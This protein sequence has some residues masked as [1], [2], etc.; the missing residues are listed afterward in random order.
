[1]RKAQIYLTAA[2]LAFL[3][4]TSLSALAFAPDGSSYEGMDNDL[5][6]PDMWEGRSFSY[7]RDADGAYLS[8]MMTEENVTDS[9]YISV[10]TYDGLQIYYSA[11]SGDWEEGITMDIGLDVLGIL[12]FKDL[13]DDGEYDPLVDELISTLPLSSS[14]LHLDFIPGDDPVEPPE[15]P[16][17]S[18]DE[19][20]KGYEE[21]YDEGY[22]VGYQVGKEH[23]ETGMEYFPDPW[24]YFPELEDLFGDWD[25]DWYDDDWDEDWDNWYDD[26]WDDEWDLP[27]F[28]IIENDDGSITV[29]IIDPDGTE[30]SYTFDSYDELEDWLMSQ[31]PD[32]WDD[33]WDDWEDDWDLP[34]FEVIEN[35]DGTI[36][37]VIIHEDGTEEKLL[38]QDYIE[39]EEWFMKEIPEIPGELPE[40]PEYPPEMPELDPYYE[41]YLFGLMDGFFLGYMEGYGIDDDAFLPCCE[42]EIIWDENDHDEWGW[43][44]DHWY[45]EPWPMPVD[46]FL[47]IQ[48]EKEIYGT[49]GYDLSY[50]VSDL[51]GYVNFN[52]Y[53]SGPLAGEMAFKPVLGLEIHVD[54]PYTR[55]DTQT[56]VIMDTSFSSLSYTG[57]VFYILEDG[58]VFEGSE[59]SIDT[60]VETPE[61]PW[62][63]F[64]KDGNELSVGISSYY[65]DYRE[66]EDLYSQGIYSFEGLIITL[67]SS[68]NDHVP[69]EDET[70]DPEDNPQRPGDDNLEAGD[71]QEEDD[72][73]SFK[74]SDD[75]ESSEKGAASDDASIDGYTVIGILMIAVIIGL[76]IT[77]GYLAY[78]KYR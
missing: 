62:T 77:A 46:H 10:S 40:D 78:R 53:A 15:D 57:G 6:Y 75:E 9:V 67:P 48:A 28:E 29:L 72:D 55:N 65:R 24:E 25:K 38:F 35:D 21:G 70:E 59:G 36:T 27:Y 30:E 14:F 54:Y 64:D 1:M 73:E 20:D 76:S 69:P 51:D 63:V 39:F 17:P 34:Y 19:W 4:I 26:D 7:N 56:T 58:E 50:S 42:E 49:E 2:S 23:A 47:P 32:D 5:I 31:I 71:E 16:E 33:D 3:V 18:E 74:R 8:S 13:D 37:V 61:I 12:E 45:P 41:G 44:E 66:W 22:E 68:I 52:I 60:D 43:D 11:S